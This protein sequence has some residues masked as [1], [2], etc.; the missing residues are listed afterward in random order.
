MTK[1]YYLH[2]KWDET[3]EKNNSVAGDRGVYD[4]EITQ[5]CKVTLIGLMERATVKKLDA[6]G[7]TLDVPKKG[8][9]RIPLNKT[10]HISFSSG[11]QVAG[12]WVD[13]CLSFEITFSPL[14]LKEYKASLP[15]FETENCDADAMYRRGLAYEAGDGVQADINEAVALMKEAA[16][17]GSKDALAWLEDYYFDDDAGVQAHS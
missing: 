14:S 7:V 12:D 1:K 11:Y 15:L 10:A 5:G 17:L 8:E 6:D 4:E 3:K 9:Y 2:I 16:E 13:E